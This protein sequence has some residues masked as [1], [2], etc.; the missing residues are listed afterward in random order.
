ML[1]SPTTDS[2]VSNVLD[3][4]RLPEMESLD[5]IPAQ[6]LDPAADTCELCTHTCCCTADE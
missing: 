6:D 3:L 5:L 1:N 4:Q 2:A